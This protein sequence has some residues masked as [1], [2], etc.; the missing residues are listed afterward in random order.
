MSQKAIQ[1]QTRAEA[2]WEYGQ[3]LSKGNLGLQTKAL[4]CFSPKL[5]PLDKKTIKT[6]LDRTRSSLYPVDNCME[7]H[8]L[9]QLKLPSQFFVFWERL[10]VKPAQ[11]I[12]RHSC[13]KWTQFKEQDINL[14]LGR[15]EICS[16]LLFG[17]QGLYFCP[18]LC[19]NWKWPVE[20]YAESIGWIFPASSW[21]YTG[22][23]HL[24]AGTP[25]PPP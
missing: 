6:Q 7:Q 11:V 2:C 17:A 25:P 15:Y 24:P 4:P 8:R 10:C 5:I 20:S 14:K 3:S 9:V 19:N 18:I 21:D 1:S 22:F 16:F 13:C 12:P 23:L